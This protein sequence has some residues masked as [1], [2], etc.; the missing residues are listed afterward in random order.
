MA[1]KVTRAE[2]AE[3]HRLAVAGCEPQAI[4]DRMGRSPSTVRM[5]L[6]VAPAEWPAVPLR[7]VPPPPHV[8]QSARK[9]KAQ[10]YA[11]LTT[12]LLSLQDVLVPVHP[13]LVD[14]PLVEVVRMQWAKAGRQTTP[15]LEALGRKAVH[16]G[17]NL[18]MAAGR[19]SGYSRAW[20]AEH[21]SKW[22]RPRAV[23][24]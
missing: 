4:A 9:A 12:G 21:G 16:D 10:V 13:A 15:T 1:A 23:A 19:A 5:A 7:S 6:R 20:V 2:V 11:D 18:M 8:S 17:V 24:S 3:M 14:L 22:A